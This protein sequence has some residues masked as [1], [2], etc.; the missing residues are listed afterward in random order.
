MCPLRIRE[1]GLIHLT[2]IGFSSHCLRPKR[3]AWGWAFPSAVRSLRATAVRFGFLRLLTEA[4]SFSSSCRS[5]LP[6]TRWHERRFGSRS[7]ELTLSRTGPLIPPDSR[8]PSGHRLV[9]LRAARHYWSRS[10]WG[11]YWPQFENL[12]RPR[13]DDARPFVGREHES[14]NEN[15]SNCRHWSR[16]GARTVR[17]L[18]AVH[19]TSCEDP[20]FVVGQHVRPP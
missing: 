10:L 14:S 5:M 7:K 9:P 1:R 16:H 2:L 11:E 4:R 13:L 18:T 20:G 17:R 19:S 3:V 8:H 15:K 12:R 6:R